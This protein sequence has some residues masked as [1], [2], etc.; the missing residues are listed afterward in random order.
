MKLLAAGLLSFACLI[1]IGCGQMPRLSESQGQS[2]SPE[3]TLVLVTGITG[4]QGGGVA[5]ALLDQG[6][7]VRG[8]SRNVS[9]E[10]S[11]AWSARGVQMVQGDFNDPNSI[12]AAVAGVDQ[13]FLNITEQTPNYIDAAKHAIDVAYFTGATHIVFT[14]NIPADTELGFD[15]NPTGT[16]R[17]IEMH[18]RA[19]G[20]SYT[21]LRIPFMMENLM[22]ERDMAGL[23][24]NG[25][26]DYG[27][28]GTVAYYISS[29]DMG[30]LAA[31]A[32]A[33]PQGWNGREANMASDALTYK[34]VAEVLSRVSGLEIPYRVAPWSEMRGPFVPNFQFFETLTRD[35]YHI[36]ELRAEF[37][38]IQTL[39][40]YL[41]SQDFGPKV[42]A[43]VAASR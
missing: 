30:L 8:L 29:G 41:I 37:P 6:F 13:M 12:T 15:V 16:K 14:S 23:P 24:A 4:N 2:S 7:K 43:A 42:R 1:L 22:R 31:A 11:Q 33:D 10:A 38:Q 9:S 18:L 39:E 27:A 36:D 20:N 26:V 28:E 19:S 40:Q 21:T 5:E 32:F 35:D 3:N 25:V 17:A 34:E